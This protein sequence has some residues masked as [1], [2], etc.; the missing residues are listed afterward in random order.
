MFWPIATLKISQFSHRLMKDQV[1]VQYIT[2]V[3]GTRIRHKLPNSSF[4]MQTFS[5]VKIFEI[6]TLAAIKYC[7]D[8]KTRLNNEFIMW[9][10]LNLM[11][12][13]NSLH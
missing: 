13:Y 2:L 12:L 9:P 7:I 3:S 5:T 8:R 11:I 6:Q 4:P 10:F 1:E